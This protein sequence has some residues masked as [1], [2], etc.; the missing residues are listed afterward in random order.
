M[1]A[2]AMVVA[3][4]VSAGLLGVA[5]AVVVAADVL[6]GVGR[7]SDVYQENIMIGAA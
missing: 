3:V 6:T 7:L 1:L 5:A 2:L 4:L